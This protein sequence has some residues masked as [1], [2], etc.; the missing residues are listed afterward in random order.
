M[1]AHPLASA[2]QALDVYKMHAERISEITKEKRRR[3]LEEVQKRRAYRRAHGLERDDSVAAANAVTEGVRGM[4]AAS[5]VAGAA[6]D[7]AAYV[8]FEGRK[9]AGPPV[10]RWLGIWS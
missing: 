7:E 8:D 9:G 5:P 3:A 4:E 2:R 1:F 10:K 6:L